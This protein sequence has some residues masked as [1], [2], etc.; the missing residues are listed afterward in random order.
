[1]YIKLKDYDSAWLK[2]FTLIIILTFGTLVAIEGL[3]FIAG[4]GIFYLIIGYHLALLFI[5]NEDS[6]WKVQETTMIVFMFLALNLARVIVIVAITQGKFVGFITSE[7]GVDM[8][9]NFMLMDFIS[10]TIGLLA[11]NANLANRQA[12]YEDVKNIVD[13]KNY[14]LDVYNKTFVW[15]DKKGKEIKIN[16]LSNGPIVRD[17]IGEYALHKDTPISLEVNG[18]TYTTW[19]RVREFL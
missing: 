6:K 15:K 14:I 5:S 8:I 16:F 17:S 2:G 18:K 7:F 13:N 9:K 4:L 1:M 19:F 3:N 10:I 11:A 12:I